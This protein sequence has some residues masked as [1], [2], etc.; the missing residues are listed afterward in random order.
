MANEKYDNLMV[1][2]TTGK[3]NWAGDAIV[4]ML[5]TGVTFNASHVT[6]VE[7]GGSRMS[8]V[9]ITR[10]E[11]GAGG[12]L[13]G[14]AVSFSYMPKDTDFQ[15][16]ITKDSGPGTTPSLLAFYDSDA[17]GDSLRLKNNGTLIVRPQSLLPAEDTGQG[18]WVTI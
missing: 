18:A 6:V 15:M 17:E 3:L 7:A 10:R 5:M 1:M 9:P 4:A 11:V 13:L 8:M 2:M 14:G 12:A 16:L